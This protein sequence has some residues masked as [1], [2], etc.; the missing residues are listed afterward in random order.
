MSQY[1]LPLGLNQF[2]PP[3]APHD[4]PSARL[5]AHGAEWLS[6]TELLS[7]L[8]QG[9]GLATSAASVVA[10]ILLKE[11]GST[12]ALL[13]W[14]APDFRRI[15]GISQAKAA[16]LAAAVEFARRAFQTPPSAAPLLNSAEQIYTYMRPIVAGSAVEK[17]FVLCLNR[18]NRLIKCRAI[19]TGTATAAM[20]HPREVLR[21]A[22]SVTGTPVTGIAVCHNH[23]SGDPCPSSPDIAVTRQLREACKAVDIELLDHVIVGVPQHDP[24]GLGYYSFRKAGML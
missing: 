23:P 4:S 13:S 9:G 5:E 24:C 18:K 22:L 19:T 14:S 2:A 16:Q 7:L 8:L 20:A 17:F 3:V 15:P 1:L 11:A 12:Q 6:D 21:E 10:A